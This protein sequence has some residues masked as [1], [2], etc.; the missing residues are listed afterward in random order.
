MTFVQDPLVFGLE[1][2][3]PDEEIQLP[4]CAL[5]SEEPP[6]E[7]DLHLQQIM[8]LLEYLNSWWQDRTVFYASANSIRSLNAL[9]ALQLNYEN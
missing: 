5:Y 4:P 7:S 6:L 3:V 2:S 8:L 9:I 1:E